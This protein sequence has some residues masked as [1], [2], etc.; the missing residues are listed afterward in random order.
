VRRHPGKLMLPF[1][2]NRPRSDS[3]LPPAR[4]LFYQRSIIG[5]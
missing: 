3:D 1:R 5:V 2:Q 4:P